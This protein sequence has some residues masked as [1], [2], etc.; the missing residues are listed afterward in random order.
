MALDHRRF[1]SVEP[2]AERD[3]LDPDSVCI[4]EQFVAQRA[5]NDFAVGP[6]MVTGALARPDDLQLAAVQDQPRAIATSPRRCAATIAAQAPLPQASVS[7]APRSNTRRRSKS[8]PI[9]RAK[10]ILARSGNIGWCSSRAPS[11][12]DVQT[13]EPIDEKDRMRV[14]HVDRHGGR[15]ARLADRHRQGIARLRQRNLAPV[16]AGHAHRHGN[17]AI[18][19]QVREEAGDRRP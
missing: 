8:G 13:V 15:Q 18:R 9:S 3:D 16:Q 7:P 14:A 4:V 1:E 5:G 10:P 2:A 19:Q 12:R 17:P 6:I 11:A